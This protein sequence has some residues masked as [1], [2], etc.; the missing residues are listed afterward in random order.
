MYIYIYYHIYKDRNVA[1]ILWRYPFEDLVW[2]W[3][4]SFLDPFWGI[5]SHGAGIRP[6]VLQLNWL[7]PAIF[8]ENKTEI[9]HG[10]Q[11]RTVRWIGLMEHVKTCHTH[12]QADRIWVFL[13]IRMIKKLHWYPDTHGIHYLVT[14]PTTM[15]I[16]SPW[17]QNGD[18]PPIITYNIEALRI[19]SCLQ[20]V[21]DCGSSLNRIANCKF[22]CRF[23]W[24]S[25]PA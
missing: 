17:L 3:I 20:D 7:N 16:T 18:K 10:I 9:G 25:F 21:L 14:F 4:C 8:S 11:M 24:G 13:D 5:S 23:C 1:N 22:I 6:L 19:K 12:L 2:Y 15:I